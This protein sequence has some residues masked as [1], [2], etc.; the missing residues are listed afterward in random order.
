M[1]KSKGNVIDPVRLLND[2]GTD[3]VRYWTGTSR[4]GQDTVLSP[5][6]LQQGKRLVT[7]LWNAVKLAHIALSQGQERP[8]TPR[9]DL[10]LGLI[11]HPLDLWLLARLG[12][13]VKQATQA[14]E[15]Y[16]YATALRVTE[17]FFWRTYC[18]NYLEMVKARTRFIGEPDADQR[19]ALLTLH[20]ASNVLVRL[21]AP[22]LPYITE[23]LNDILHGHEASA[24]PTI[25]ARSQW[26][27]IDDQISTGVD[28]RI[29]DAFVEILAAARKVKSELAVSIRA[30]V[31]RLSISSVGGDAGA[32]ST[33]LRRLEE[34]LK[35]V[36]TAE[37]VTWADAAPDEV[38][39]AL[40][41]D[42]R[43][44]VALE[45]AIEQP[46]EAG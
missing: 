11:T 25:H 10:E 9:Q 20:H 8:T 37:E 19:S 40:S 21:F 14:F 35:A 15:D 32:P 1:S 4:L 17:D 5:N 23:T 26:P 39:N 29:G 24:A 36:L 34:D 12:E 44:R 6:T 38:P 2:H 22:V 13:T 16:E 30:P 27:A 7:K 41:P 31:R 46:A 43:F 18:D 42:G 28:L 3:V 33:A 45:M